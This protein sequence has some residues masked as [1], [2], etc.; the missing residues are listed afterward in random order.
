MQRYVY[1]TNFKVLCLLTF[2]IIVFLCTLCGNCQ[3]AS[4][5]DTTA[6]YYTRLSM[7]YLDSSGSRCFEYAGKAI[8]YAHRERNSRSIADAYNANALAFQLNGQYREALA[9]FDSVIVYAE[10]ANDIFRLN[11]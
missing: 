8:E 3:A 2:A 10:A 7:Q 5:T 9:L 6:R 4:D 11:T 1:K